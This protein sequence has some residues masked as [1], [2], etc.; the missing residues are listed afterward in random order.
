MSSQSQSQSQ[1]SSFSEDSFSESSK[2]LSQTLGSEDSYSQSFCNS[3]DSLDGFIISDDSSL[4][5]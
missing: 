4:K 2:D 5:K 1:N 3:P